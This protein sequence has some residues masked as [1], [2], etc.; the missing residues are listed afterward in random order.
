MIAIDK[1]D[2][3]TFKVSVETDASTQHIV[4]LKPDVFALLARGRAS[5]EALIKVA[6]EFLLEREPNTSIMGAF[7]LQVIGQHYPE[8]EAEVKR[9]L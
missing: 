9:R 5:E 4:T 2:A 8:F 3:T 7:E 6:F 1:V